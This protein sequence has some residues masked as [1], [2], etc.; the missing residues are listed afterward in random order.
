MFRLTSFFALACLALVATAYLTAPQGAKAQSQ[1]D[2]E[3]N[4][5]TR[6][7]LAGLGEERTAPFHARFSLN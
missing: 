6:N 1:S 4:P 2:N 3:S 7:R 5:E